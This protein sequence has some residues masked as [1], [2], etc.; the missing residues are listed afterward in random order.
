[1]PLPAVAPNTGST[2]VVPRANTGEESAPPA[3]RVI[4]PVEIE[5]WRRV[6]ERAIVTEL[7][8]YLALHPDQAM[9][10][11]ELRFALRPDMEAAARTWAGR[12][13][14]TGSHRSDRACGPG[15]APW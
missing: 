14:S 8:C 11:D 1:V 4:G 5:G 7:A 3:V 10:G 2:G 6:P 9:S 13:P 12:R 15:P